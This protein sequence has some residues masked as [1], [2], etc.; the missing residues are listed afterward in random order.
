MKERNISY[1]YLSVS[2]SVHTALRPSNE[3]RLQENSDISATLASNSTGSYNA[4]QLLQSGSSYSGELH[5][6]TPPAFK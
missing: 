6:N 2:H 1:F 5:L 4:E 3:E